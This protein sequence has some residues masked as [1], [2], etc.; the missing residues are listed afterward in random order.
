MANNQALNEKLQNSMM[1]SDKTAAQVH[2]KKKMEGL[3]AQMDG[4]IAKAVG[5]VMD[6]DRFARIALSLYSNNQAFWQCDTISFLSAL[7]MSAQ[8][9]LEPNT[10]LGQAYLIPYGDKVTFQIGYKG[11][12]EL[13]FRSGMYKSIY[14]HEVFKN[15]EFNYEYGLDKQLRHIPA[16]EPEGEPVCYYAVYKL[17]NGG[18]DFV[19][20]S[21]EK[22]LRHAKKYSKTFNK[23]GS[24]WQSSFDSMALKSVLI[25]A[26]KYSPKSVEMQKAIMFDETIKGEIKE[27][28]EDVSNVEIDLSQAVEA[29]YIVV[30]EQ[31]QE[32][33]PEKQPEKNTNK[34]AAANKQQPE[35]QPDPTNEENLALDAQISLME[36][37]NEKK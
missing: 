23:S 17:K 34:K 8:A 35:K 11:I 2:P 18:E 10:V 33:E 9:G 21:R 31:D 22:I 12:L 19:V 36:A 26:L 15:D 16:D 5:K 20:W 13:A 32:P 14:A 4:Q 3:L 6:K 1:K 25:A 37:Q 30:D 28:M 7:M 27:N 24:S 29:D